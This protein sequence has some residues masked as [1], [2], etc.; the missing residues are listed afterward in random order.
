MD[1]HFRGHDMLLFNLKHSSTV[2]S[3]KAPAAEMIFD[4]LI[5]V[6]IAEFVRAGATFS[7]TPCGYSEKS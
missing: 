4:D 7:K 2:L 5:F 1:A 6:R 3:E